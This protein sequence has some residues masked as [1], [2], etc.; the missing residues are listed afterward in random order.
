MAQ[1]HKLHNHDRPDDYDSPIAKTDV[2]F[3]GS[4]ASRASPS[5]SSVGYTH[6]CQFLSGI[7][8]ELIA[9]NDNQ[10][11]NSEIRL[12]DT[13]NTLP[14]PSSAFDTTSADSSYFADLGGLGACSRERVRGPSNNKKY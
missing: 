10:S 3:A 11:P 9:E 14:S 8:I 12:V 6:T 7:F 13:R 1:W 4:S 5:P 2:S